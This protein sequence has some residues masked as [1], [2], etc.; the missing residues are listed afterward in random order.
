VK[1]LLRRL[2]HVRAE[3]PACSTLSTSRSHIGRVRAVNEDRV[4]ELLDL[5]LWALADGM[6]GHSRGDAA[7]EAVIGALAALTGP[8]SPDRLNAALQRANREIYRTWGGKSGATLVLLHVDQGVGTLRW[9]GDSRA[10]LI[11]NERLDLLTRDHSVVQEL[12]EAGLV[13]ADRA[14]HHPHANVITRALGIAPEPDMETMS[15]ALQPGDRVLLCS[16]GLSRSL[17]D[18]DV[19]GRLPLELQADRLLTNALQRDGG[20]NTSLVLVEAT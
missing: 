6:G 2:A 3:V 18:R 12:V 1:A 7:A 17:N 9:A 16:D 13:E 11:R 8:I 4:L 15:V 20:D 14:A 5:R 19:Q 10:Y